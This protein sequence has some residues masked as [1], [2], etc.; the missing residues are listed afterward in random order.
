MTGPIEL[1]LTA[2]HHRLEALLD[3][4]TADPE[5]FDA[6]AF[7]RFRAGLLRHIGI[8]EKILLPDARR[9]RGGEP[10]AVHRR[11]RVDHSA[12]VSLCVPTPSHAIAAEIRGLLA[13]HDALEVG[14][15]ALYA[16][17]DALAGDEAAAVVARMRLAPE[18]PLA[19]HFDGHGVYRR[20][21]DALAAASHHLVEKRAG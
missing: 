15:G 12:L 3:E 17:C 5:R 20:A 18:V 1:E 19:P 10:L 4:A 8:E 14:P 16:V 2:D 9:R 7:E 6:A 11:L 21:E 13:R